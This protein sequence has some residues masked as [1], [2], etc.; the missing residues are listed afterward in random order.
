MAT[1]CCDL[2]ENEKSHAKAS[3]LKQHTHNF[4]INAYTRFDDFETK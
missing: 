1:H 3:A 2:K 4:L